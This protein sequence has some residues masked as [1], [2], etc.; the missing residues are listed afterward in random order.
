MSEGIHK[1]F[2]SRLKHSLGTQFVCLSVCVYNYSVFLDVLRFFQSTIV[3]DLVPPPK[4][5]LVPPND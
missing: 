2:L 4:K 1:H 5:H 3:T